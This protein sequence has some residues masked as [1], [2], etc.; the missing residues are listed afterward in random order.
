MVFMYGFLKI[1]IINIFIPLSLQDCHEFCNTCFDAKYNNT[2][3]QCISCIDKFSLLYNTT[4]CVESLWYPNYYKNKSIPNLTILYPCS[5][6]PE[7]N[8]Y[9]CDPSSPSKDG[10]ICLSCNPGFFYDNETRKCS[11]CKDNEYSIIV[12]DFDGCSQN[13][14]FFCHK[15]ITYCN[16]SLGNI[17]CPDEAPFFDKINNYCQEYECTENEKDNCIIK[18]KNYKN[19]TFSYFWFNNNPKY[20]RYPSYN[21]DKSGNLLIELTTELEF[22]PTFIFYEKNK[23]RKL[24]FFDNEGR[25][26]FNKLNDEF[27]RTINTRKKT[28]RLFSTS[29]SLKNIYSGKY[30]Y[31]LNLESMDYNLEFIDLETFEVTKENFFDVSSFYGNAPDSVN[32]PS[33]LLLELNEKNQYLMSMFVRSATADNDMFLTKELELIIYIFNIDETN[34]E[35]IDINSLNLIC[36]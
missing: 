30:N 15:Y 17:T 26:L 3:M 36:V 28:S 23:Y 34:G 32:V 19:R 11:K 24:Y 5:I 18:N 13:F 4:N 16:I 14:R 21:V 6:F 25:G 12:N 9:E 7:A 31:F 1:F 35:K 8:C 2:N 29:I 10:G 22:F 27:E 20:I 33:I